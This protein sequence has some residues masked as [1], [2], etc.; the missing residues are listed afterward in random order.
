MKNLELTRKI[1]DS[2]SANNFEACLS[3]A[4]ENV[5]IMAHAFGMEFN[6]KSEFNAFMQGFKQAFP[7]MNLKHVTELCQG[8]HVAIEMTATG[9]HSGPLQTPNGI[10]PATG[11]A[12]VLNVAEFF[13]WK[14]GLLISINN[15]QDAGSLLRQIGAL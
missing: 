12:V 9:T 13:E 1:H 6:G 5:K 11:K 15:Y 2:F 7:D 14:N 10:I 3:I 8:D 4:D